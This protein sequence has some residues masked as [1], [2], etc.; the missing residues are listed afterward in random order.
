[1]FIASGGVGIASTDDFAAVSLVGD[2][3]AKSCEAGS[4]A[5]VVAANNAWRRGKVFDIEAAS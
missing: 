1:M 2:S 3:D 4:A 5:A